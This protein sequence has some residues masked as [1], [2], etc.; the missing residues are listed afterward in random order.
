[1][2]SEARAAS[3]TR[4]SF[5]VDVDGPESLV[6]FYWF[7]DALT[8]MPTG[9]MWEDPQWGTH[10]WYDEDGTL[11]PCPIGPVNAPNVF[12]KVLFRRGLILVSGLGTIADS[13]RKCALS[14]LL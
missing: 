2:S 12:D 11:E 8:H 14:T 6:P 1:M 13:P 3:L 5:K 9:W 10:F 7:D 4:R